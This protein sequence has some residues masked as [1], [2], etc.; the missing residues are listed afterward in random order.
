MGKSQSSVRQCIRSHS[1]S[2]QPMGILF[3]AISTPESAARRLP[4]FCVQMGI[5]THSQSENGQLQTAISRIVVGTV[6]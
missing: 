1:L 4:N 2:E 6:G 5:S 3:L